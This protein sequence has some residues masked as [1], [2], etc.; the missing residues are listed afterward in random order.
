MNVFKKIKSILRKIVG[1]INFYISTKNTCEVPK[2]GKYAV[3]NLS[4]FL[5]NADAGRYSFILCK[6]LNY[7]GYKIVMKL[8]R[9]FFTRSATYKE[10]LLKQYFKFIRVYNSNKDSITLF[11]DGSKIKTIKLYY[12]FKYSKEN[13]DA[14]YLPFSSHPFYFQTA[15]LTDERLILRKREK[16]INIFFAGNI[17]KNLY[18]NN[19]QEEFS[20]II[21]RV[22][23]LEHIQKNHKDDLIQVSDKAVLYELLDSPVT[24]NKLVICEAKTPQESWLEILSSCNFYLC[25]PGVRMPWSHNATEAMSVGA[26]P[27]IQY[28]NLFHPPLEHMKNCITYNS[29][30]EL[31]DAV[32]IALHLGK[33]ELAT[34]RSAAINYYETYLAPEAVVQA[35]VNF[36]ES[37]ELAMDIAIPFLELN[38]RF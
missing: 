25:L 3:L 36:S 32:H 28:G 34:L 1:V 24:V 11:E 30:E 5:I 35:V 15:Q 9:P 26:I 27:I 2:D 23:V 22:N 8:D 29:Y 31:D 6:Y 18:S 21:S 33:E 10:L 17:D 19:L 14:Y 13:I 7:S 38:D 20:S 16:K 4:G 37:K 12:G